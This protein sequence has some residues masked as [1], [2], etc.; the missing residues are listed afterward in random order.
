[1][2]TSKS[3]QQN[4]CGDSLASPEKGIIIE[5][6]STFGGSFID[7]K[8]GLKRLWLKTT[9]PAAYQAEVGRDELF[10]G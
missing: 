5:E 6:Y 10:F 4:E 3:K 1:M 2:F 7:V 8:G 9:F